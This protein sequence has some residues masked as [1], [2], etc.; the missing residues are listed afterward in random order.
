MA[1]T[2]N[3]WDHVVKYFTCNG[4]IQACAYDLCVRR[5]PKECLSKGQRIPR[6]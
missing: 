4:C 3:K 5:T 1:A 6:D 2:A